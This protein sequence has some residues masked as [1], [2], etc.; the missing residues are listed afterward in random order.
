MPVR[1]LPHN[2]SLEHLR[3][4]AKADQ[5]GVRAGD[6]ASLALVQE[7][8]PRL[9]ALASAGAP[10]PQFALADAQLVIA[11]QYGFASWPRLRKHLEVV[12]QYSR[13]PHRVSSSAH[14]GEKTPPA[15][16][17]GALDALADE[18]L[19]L[20]CLTY[21]GDSP[22]YREQARQ[23]LA[24]HPELRTASLHTMA[25]CGEA[26]AARAL[27]ERDPSLVNRLG[28]PHQWE[29]LLY[30][31][32]GRLG[33][34]DGH[35][36]A[37]GSALATARVLLEHGAD[38][39]AGY[40]WDGLTSPFT[41]LTGAF[42][43]GEDGI[44]QPPHPDSLDLARLLLEAGADPNDSQTLYNRQFRAGAGHLELLLRYGLGRGD[45][46]VWHAR[47]GPSHATPAEMVQDQLLW[48]ART[49]M[50]ERVRLLL[51]H[52]VEVDGRGTEHPGFHAL[53]AYEL[54]VVN[55]HGEV[56]E[57]LRAAG[58]NTDTLDPVAEFLGICLRGDH[59]EVARQLAADPTVLPRALAR[60]PHAMLRA[61]EHER[62]EAV[63]VLAGLGFD[64]NARRRTTA[65]HEAAWRGNLELVT[66][67]LELGADPTLLDTAF[68]APPLG[69]ARHNQQ[70]EVAEY[71]SERTLP[72]MT[73][74]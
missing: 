13:S 42:G 71:L 43:E 30:L 36:G 16:N 54:A 72:D 66:L 24:E 74:Q 12:A 39:N 21:G 32:Y 70:H 64:V 69:W 20:A 60:E 40:L 31:T 38:P 2:P 27:L 34:S 49:D 46:G 11:R 61:A 52:S 58:A 62:P 33:E 3:K 73:V 59:T 45:G 37:R 19:R 9:E 51:A 22:A 6:A 4:Q 53:T 57:L 18:F 14:S 28:G 26:E 29:P 10:L 41:A 5:Q 8:H 63:R 47:L 50:P 1:R 44:N 48:A 17:P 65:L 56:V 23:L 55:G 7:F 35:S 25:A 68:N 67:L 15:G